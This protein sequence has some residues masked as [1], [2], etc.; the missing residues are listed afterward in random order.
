MRFKTARQAYSVLLSR[1]RNIYNTKVQQA[2]DHRLHRGSDDTDLWARRWFQWNIFSDMFSPKRVVIIDRHG[3]KDYADGGSDEKSGRTLFGLLSAFAIIT[4]V[5]VGLYSGVK[6]LLERPWDNHLF[7]YWKRFRSKNPRWIESLFELAVS[8]AGAAIVGSV[9]WPL[10][11]LTSF[12]GVADL[13]G[14]GSCA[15]GLMLGNFIAVQLKRSMFPMGT[16]YDIGYRIPVMFND[17]SY[18]Y[19]RVM[20]SAELDVKMSRYLDMVPDS[21]EM[22]RLDTATLWL[23][24]KFVRKQI[25][26]DVVEAA[27]H[28]D[29]ESLD[30][31]YTFLKNLPEENSNKEAMVCLA[32][33]SRDNIRANDL[34][35]VVKLLKQHAVK[36]CS[37]EKCYH[38]KGRQRRDFFQYSAERA[39]DNLEVIETQLRDFEMGTKFR[40]SYSAA[41]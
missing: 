18:D 11:S 35:A 1:A 15:L 37:T 40:G 21:K 14:L 17:V 28:A 31:F 24:V 3:R 27:D 5:V 20:E 36:P 13:M 12:A 10:A 8:F 34:S 39:C 25:K 16:G 38:S 9:M 26:D 30:K 19:S 29:F 32:E 4:S 41:A 2:K 33:M 22:N 23:F 6:Y 7:K